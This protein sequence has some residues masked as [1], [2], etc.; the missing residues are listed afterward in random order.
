MYVAL[1]ESYSKILA[2][3]ILFQA[4]YARMESGLVT[5]RALAV[6]SLKLH[7]ERNILTEAPVLSHH[8]MGEAFEALIGAIYL[9]SQS[10]LGMVQ[11][12]LRNIEFS[13]V[14][15]GTETPTTA[16]LKSQEG[17]SSHPESVTA[18][19]VQ[20]DEVSGPGPISASQMRTESH[21]H[22]AGNTIDVKNTIGG[23]GPK[24]TTA[25]AEPVD[26]IYLPE[27]CP[28]DNLQIRSIYDALAKVL[29]RI[30][31]PS[32]VPRKLESQIFETLYKYYEACEDVIDLCSWFPALQ[33]RNESLYSI[34]SG[35][36]YKPDAER[37][38]LRTRSRLTRRRRAL[39][40]AWLSQDEGLFAPNPKRSIFSNTLLSEFRK[41]VKRN[42]EG[43]L[44]TSTVIEAVRRMTSLSE[45]EA[46][47]TA[48]RLEEQTRNHLRR[49]MGLPDWYDL[50]ENKDKVLPPWRLSLPAFRSHADTIIPMEVLVQE[51]VPIQPLLLLD[52]PR[53]PESDF[54]AVTSAAQQLAGSTS[55]RF[56]YLEHGWSRSIPKQNRRANTKEGLQL[57]PYALRDSRPRQSESKRSGD[58]MLRWHYYEGS[59]QSAGQ[60][61]SREDNDQETRRTVDRLKNGAARCATTGLE[62]DTIQTIQQRY[63]T[64]YSDC[65]RR[66]W[67]GQ[68]LGYLYGPP[69]E[70]ALSIF[71]S[72]RRYTD[73]S[74]Y[75]YSKYDSALLAGRVVIRNSS[76][77]NPADQTVE[78]ETSKTRS[79]NAETTIANTEASTREVAVTQVPGEKDEHRKAFAR[80]KPTVS[81]ERRSSTQGHGRSH[82]LIRKHAIRDRLSSDDSDKVASQPSARNLVRRVVR[83]GLPFWQ[84]QSFEDDT[85]VDSTSRT[86]KLQNIVGLVRP[87]PTTGT[88]GSEAQSAESASA[89]AS[90]P[91][92]PG[93]AGGKNQFSP[94][95]AP[96]IRDTSSTTM[97]LA[98]R[99]MRAVMTG[100]KVW[101]RDQKSNVA[102]SFTSSNPAMRASAL[103]LDQ[104]KDKATKT[105]GESAKEESK[106]VEQKTNEGRE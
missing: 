64:M 55:V 81:P 17:P 75:L 88:D 48:L 32:T 53:Q 60:Y 29:P 92:Q 5:R 104:S 44:R 83:T 82:G 96:P 84:Q 30:W 23:Y 76:N 79:T 66:R 67:V 91:K 93:D 21:L 85:E 69:M 16:Q 42:Y 33:S 49:T 59:P 27:Y 37:Q 13:G 58:R 4:R 72:T 52:T 101:F 87:D 26:R 25:G 12:V 68:A 6:E 98:F 70:T 2:I 97:N 57:L 105:Q 20:V 15:T 62:T 95:T 63:T 7:I 94:L 56:V 35:G 40:G 45:R 31:A 36:K 106:S 102:P 71:S 99:A 22:P 47:L 28:Q 61:M 65:W 77:D 19:G 9:D 54:D 103:K 41:V 78:Q 1:L 14:T 89:L 74:T 90:T 100:N 34:H 46:F 8:T 50:P 80:T 39:L 3:L 10:D 18:V 73:V 43:G 24:P 51:K 11:K 86:T 38:S